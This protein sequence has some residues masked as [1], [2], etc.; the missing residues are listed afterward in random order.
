M[1]MIKGNRLRTCGKAIRRVAALAISPFLKA[2]KVE[3]KYIVVDGREEE[4]IPFSE[5]IN[6]ESRVSRWYSESARYVAKVSP[7][8]PTFI[9]AF[10]KHIGKMCKD[11][12][13]FEVTY[14]Q[15]QG[16]E[17]GDTIREKASKSRPSELAP[18]ENTQDNEECLEDYS[19]L[20]I[21][22]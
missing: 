19:I 9:S 16:N 8:D 5:F 4:V 20:Q 14:Y 3:N 22:Y 21:A 12:T 10:Q 17:L 18:S 1:N 15:A 2:P 11:Y 7:M 6:T 13:I